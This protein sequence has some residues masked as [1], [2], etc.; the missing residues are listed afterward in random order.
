MTPLTTNE[1]LDKILK[2]FVMGEI[3]PDAKK[4]IQAL[5][6]QQTKEAEVRGAIKALK[7]LRAKDRYTNRDSYALVEIDRLKATLTSDKQER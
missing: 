1:E 5:L 7:K 6:D 2:Q 4:A 3:I